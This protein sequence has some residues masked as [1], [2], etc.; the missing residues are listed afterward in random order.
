MATPAST[1]KGPRVLIV[2]AHPD[3]ETAYA[4]TVYKIV[5]DLHGTVDLVVVT[6][7]EAGYKYSTLASAY[8]GYDLTNEAVGRA[9]LP[10]IRHDELLAAGKVIGLHHIYF[11]EQRDNR[12][13]RDPHEVLDSNWNVPKV[14]QELRS[15]LMKGGYDFVF[16]LLPEDSTHGHHKAATILSLEAIRD[17]PQ[18]VPHPVALAGSI[19][20]ADRPS[21]RFRE[22]AGFPI[23][24]MADT[25]PLFHLDRKQHFG[26]RKSLTYQI[27]V[28]WEIAEH[29]SQGAL[30]L[31]MG[32]GDTEEFYL[33]AM[34]EP[35]ARSKAEALFAS[36]AAQVYPELTYPGIR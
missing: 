29:K 17:L 9:H 3:D 6:N 25:V 36:L 22:L 23:T 24:R 35:S 5:H 14:R 34:N 7:G 26:F 20:S 30:Q 12:Y 32:M 10:K 2:D 1:V 8:Y 19:S 16:D 18:G 28:N 31:G 33:Y 11:L 15:I 13:T 27:I 21:P 4:V